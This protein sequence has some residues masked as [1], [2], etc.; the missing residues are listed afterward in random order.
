MHT[1]SLEPW[2]HAHL[3]GQDR[4]RGGE[5][6]VLIVAGLTAVM[7]VAE[8]VG[9]I[10]FGSMALLADGLHM[11]SHFAALGI[12][13]VAYVYARRHANDRS[14]SFGTGK[15]NALAGYSSALLLVILSLVMAWESLERLFN[16]IPI[17]FGDALFVAVIGLVVNG[18][19][20][21]M[22]GR[23]DHDDHAHGHHHDHADEHG[24]SARHSDA[25]GH[26]HDHNLRGAYLHVV[27]DALTSIL[28]ILALLGGKTFGWV[29]LDALIGI[30]GAAL[31][32][33]WAYGLIRRTGAVLLD[34]EID[35]RIATLVKSSIE[36]DDARLA[37]LHLWSIGTEGYAAALSVV[38][39]APLTAEAYKR[40][41]PHDARIVHA[42]IEVHRCPGAGAAPSPSA[43]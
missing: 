11:G 35:P 28:A 8:I 7:M 20:A 39:E 3:F 12:A 14:F 13:Y 38:S 23:H 2:Q 24:H 33:W 32:S 40:R 41:I 42:T 10:A 34:R 30:L 31:V 29:W 9:G 15:V 26:E 19:S 36:T 1:R 5:R 22:L 6:R 18:V 27:A 4:H 43:A 16:P 21:V 17:A 37:D 25:H